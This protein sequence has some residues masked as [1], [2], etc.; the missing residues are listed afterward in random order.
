MKSSSALL[1]CLSFVHAL[2]N[3][4]LRCTKIFQANYDVK[5]Q[6]LKMKKKR[7][8]RRIEILNEMKFEK[9]AVYRKFYLAQHRKKRNAATRIL[10]DVGK[11]SNRVYTTE[12]VALALLEFRDVIEKVSA[13]SVAP[14][15]RTLVHSVSLKAHA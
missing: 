9:A 6:L 3:D 1:Q 10:D 11:Q 12:R 14:I 5:R 13:K 2:N 15:S 4:I 7:I 8:H